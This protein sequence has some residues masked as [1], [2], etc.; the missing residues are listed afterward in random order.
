MFT[1]R[2]LRDVCLRIIQLSN[3]EIGNLRLQKL[4]Y[5]VQVYSLVRFGEEALFKKIKWSFLSLTL[6]FG[7]ALA[8]KWKF[9]ENPKIKELEESLIAKNKE[10]LSLNNKIIAIKS[11]LIKY[12][13][14][15]K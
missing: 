6:I 14:N 1:N 10:I 8:S 4:L 7:L 13:R 12:R 9:G 5:F 15:E 11:D 3:G 2:N